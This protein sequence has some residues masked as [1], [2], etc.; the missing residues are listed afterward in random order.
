[1]VDEIFWFFFAKTEKEITFSETPPIGID[2]L[3][4]YGTNASVITFIM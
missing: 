4:S 1:M 2:A 3:M